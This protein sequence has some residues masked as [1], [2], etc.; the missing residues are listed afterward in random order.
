MDLKIQSNPIIQTH[1]AEQAATTKQSESTKKATTISQRVFQGIKEQIHSAKNSLNSVS[2][3]FKQAPASVSK[4]CQEILN[5]GESIVKNMAPAS[6]PTIS[7]LQKQVQAFFNP[8]TTTEVKVE[9]KAELPKTVADVKKLLNEKL[10]ELRQE[11]PEYVEVQ[12]LKK[13]DR[14]CELTIYAKPEFK[15]KYQFLQTL[16]EKIEN[17]P[18][19]V[20]AEMKVYENQPVYQILGPMKFLMIHAQIESNVKALGGELKLSPN[21]QKITPQARVAIFAYT[22]GEYK[23]INPALRS[24]DAQ[25]TEIAGFVK[26]LESGLAE[27]PRFQAT[28]EAPVLK[29][30]LGNPNKNF[31]KKAFGNKQFSDKSLLSTSYNSTT[32]GMINVTIEPAKGSSD[33]PGHEVPPFLTAWKLE[34]EVL[35]PSNTSFEVVNR[36]KSPDGISWNITL[37]CLQ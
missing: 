5:K 32:S 33:F 2:N 19:K 14:N 17:H 28:K 23:M 29:R 35:F 16:K 6:N 13:I 21:E 25:S 12:E 18:Q 3:G 20:A 30:A 26:H 7:N 37:R 15:E 34:A 1:S 24:G 10:E 4:A 27:L 31:I 8:K 9:A 36:E 22:T 11:N